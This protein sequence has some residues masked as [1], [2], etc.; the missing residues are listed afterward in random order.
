VPFDTSQGCV[1]RISPQE[2]SALHMH[3]WFSSA[4]TRLLVRLT[5]IL[6]DLSETTVHE[7]DRKPTCFFT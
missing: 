6:R 7:D 1:G 5:E 4:K 2:F 3:G